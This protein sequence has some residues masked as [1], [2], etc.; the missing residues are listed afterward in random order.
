MRR[1]LRAN[2]SLTVRL[3]DRD[4]G[5]ISTT[6]TSVAGCRSIQLAQQL[7]LVYHQWNE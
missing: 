7:C 4:L 1:T 6:V 5:T 3:A 2:L